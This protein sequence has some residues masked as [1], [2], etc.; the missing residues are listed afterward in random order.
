[1]Y[2]PVEEDGSDGDDRAVAK[3]VVDGAAAEAAWRG[4]SSPSLQPAKRVPAERSDFNG[5]AHKVGGAAV[6]VWADNVA[7]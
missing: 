3:Y 6:A 7:E 1:M 4:G 5:A 2:V